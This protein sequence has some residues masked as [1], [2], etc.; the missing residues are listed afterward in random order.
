MLYD[1]IDINGEGIISISQLQQFMEQH[2]GGLRSSEKKELK[3]FESKGT[4]VPYVNPNGEEETGI[5]RENFGQLILSMGLLKESDTLDLRGPVEE[6]KSDNE[7][8]DDESSAPSA[9]SSSTVVGDRL[10]RKKPWYETAIV[11]HALLLFLP[12]PPPPSLPPSSF[13]PPSPSPQTPTTFGFLP[14]A[15]RTTP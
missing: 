7:G 14:T 5:L 4:G 6:K 12:S 8:K 11:H 13:R 1:L 15:A 3:E 2:G 9:S 10:Q